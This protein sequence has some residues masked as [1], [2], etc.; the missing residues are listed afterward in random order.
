MCCVK[1]SVVCDK[2]SRNGITIISTGVQIED[3][4]VDVEVPLL[5]N[6]DTPVIVD[7]DILPSPNSRDIGGFDLWKVGVFTSRNP[8]GSGP[9]QGYVEQILTPSQASKSLDS[10]EPLEFDDITT[11][12]DASDVGCTDYRYICLEFQKGEFSFPDFM[13]ETTD[14]EDS[15]VRCE[16]VPCPPSKFSLSVISF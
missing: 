3:M 4:E 10:D 8:R 7:V 14:G 16:L 15:I 2:I 5:P 1:S 12:F 6:G 9:R 13:F 11:P